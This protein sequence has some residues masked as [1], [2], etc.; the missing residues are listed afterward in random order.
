MCMGSVV[1]CHL[2]ITYDKIIESKIEL[3]QT[4]CGLVCESEDK[5][6]IIHMHSFIKI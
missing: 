5:D 4:F 2:S 6:M 1:W 3:L